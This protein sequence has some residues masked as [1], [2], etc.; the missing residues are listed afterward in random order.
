MALS[1]D[2]QLVGFILNGR[3]RSYLESVEFELTVRRRRPNRRPSRFLRAGASRPLAP[4][5]SHAAQPPAFTWSPARSRAAQGY[6]VTSSAWTNVPIFVIV[7]CVCAVPTLAY[8]PF[9]V[10]LG[11]LQ[12]WPRKPC[13]VLATAAV[14]L[15]TLIVF[16]FDLR[17]VRTTGQTKK[18]RVL[19][20]E[21]AI[22]GAW[23]PDRDQTARHGYASARLCCRVRRVLRI[24][25]GQGGRRF[26]P[27]H[28]R[29]AH[30]QDV[31]PGLELRRRRVRP[32]RV[33]RRGNG[34]RGRGGGV[35]RAG[36]AT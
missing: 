28:L 35:A 27:V 4:R 30:G 2:D 21:L 20:L 26:L 25:A 34:G 24:M 3:Q 36:V 23:Y 11:A 6:E 15:K 22:T 16:C 18:T 17:H 14:L 10:G 12:P 7:V 33:W 29:R 9:F 13:L 5:R 19:L 31:Q 8:E 32:R 1:Q